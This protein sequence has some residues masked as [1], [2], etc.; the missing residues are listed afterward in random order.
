V[1][2]MDR[3]GSV[4]VLAPADV[5]FRSNIVADQQSLWFNEDGYKTGKQ[6]WAISI[7]NEIM[8]NGP[9]EGGKHAGQPLAGLLPVS[10]QFRETELP[11]WLPPGIRVRKTFLTGGVAGI[12]E[13]SAPHDA[14]M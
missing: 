5:Y 4:S 6:F 3:N 2:R 1:Y 12:I 9:E 10:D 14:Q 11:P 8:R 7:R 13:I